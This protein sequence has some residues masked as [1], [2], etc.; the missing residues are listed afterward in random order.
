MVA[1]LEEDSYPPATILIVDDN[2]ANRTALIAVLE[3]LGHRVV[4]ASSGEEALRRVMDEDFAVL[5]I[6][7]QMPGMDGFETVSLLREHPRTRNTPMV[8]V[9][10]YHHDVVAARKG[11]AAGAIDY[12]IKPFDPDLLRA[13][14]QALVSLYRRGAELKRR[15]EIIHQKEM[16]AARAQTEALRAEEANRLKDKYIGILGHDLRN[17]LSAISNSAHLLLRASD[18]PERHRKSATRILRA[19]DR[20]GN[21]IRDVLDFTRGHLGGGIPIEPTSGNLAEICH[22][23]VDETKAIHPERDIVLVAHGDLSGTWDRAR[24]EQVVSNLVGNAVRHGEGQIVVEAVGEEDQIFLRV[25]NGGPPIP[26]TELPTIFEP[27]RRGPETPQRSEGLGL[28]L[29]IVR[30]IVRAHGGTVQ[31]RSSADEGTTFACIWVRSPA[32]ASSRAVV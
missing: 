30:E 14:V 11:Y 2:P 27:F 23:V 31:V 29:Y 21:M 19:S 24:L 20:M 25:K 15:A 17:P 8:F 9:S 28:G 5:L 1:E 4:N 12:I 22:R 13:K 3:A 10:A 18:L 16:E 7:V 32:D 6:D 26:V